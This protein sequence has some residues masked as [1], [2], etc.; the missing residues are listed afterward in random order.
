MDN[1]TLY[2]NFGKGSV[3]DSIKKAIENDIYYMPKGT[4]ILKDNTKNP[5]PAKNGMW[6]TSE[7]S[8]SHWFS[9]RGLVSFRMYPSDYTVATEVIETEP[10]DELKKK[11]LEFKKGILTSMDDQ[12]QKDWGFGDEGEQGQAR[13][14][15]KQLQIDA[16][17]QMINSL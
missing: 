6:L 5:R 2:E 11:F 13:P 8:I 15:K 10:Q 9:K 12:A 14:N 7:N 16:I 17:D 4:M 1:L 3:I